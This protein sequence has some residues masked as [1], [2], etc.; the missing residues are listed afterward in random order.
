MTTTEV[1]RR[2]LLL[3]SDAAPFEDVD[4]V[5]EEAGV[6]IARCHVDGESAF[7]CAGLV[8]GA[9]PLDGEQ[10]VDVAVDVRQHPWPNP[11]ARELGVTC[12]LRSDVPLVVVGRSPHPFE[13]WAVTTRDA[14]GVLDACDDAIA[15]AL[16]APRA[17]AAEAVASVL[18][19]HGMGERPF[20]V[21]LERSGGQ[22]R[23]R[24]AADVPKDVAAIAATRAAVAVRRFDRASSSLSIQL[25]A[26]SA[27]R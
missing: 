13:Q 24:I 18:A 16:E 3:S 26:P 27:Q 17:A 2:V 23:V 20:A 6:T 4:R 5:L 22:L 7:P 25:V 11:T 8:T 19:N 10:G 14:S 21:G 12:A 15:D 1:P 9:C